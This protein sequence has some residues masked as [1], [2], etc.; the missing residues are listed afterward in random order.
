MALGVA[1]LWNEKLQ[2]AHG[3]APGAARLLTRD[4]CK[5]GAIGAPRIGLAMDS[6]V[7]NGTSPRD[8]HITN[9]LLFGFLQHCSNASFHR[10]LC[11]LCEEV[12]LLKLQ[13]QGQK[14]HDDELQT[15]GNR[16]SRVFEGE[17]QPDSERQ[18]EIVQSIARNLAEIGDSLDSSIQPAL[19]DNLAAQFQNPNLSEEDRRRCLAAALDQLARVLP[20]D[21]EQEKMLLTLA[22][23]LV[24]KVAAR[25]PS[26]LCSVFRTTASLINQNLLTYLRNL[27]RN[28]RTS[29]VKPCPLLLPPRA[30]FPGSTAGLW[31]HSLLWEPK[32][33]EAAS[34]L[35]L[36]LP[37]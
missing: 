16:S 6:Q 37:R 14:F 25:T 34:L 12:P 18:E 10:E 13:A 27:I 26:L 15:D 28:V 19:V 5:P 1:G 11:A 8:E 30:H 17:E 31:Q 7:S 3:V 33:Q 4:T 29:E 35:R 24:K 36:G 22:M 9:L 23:L 32:H 21:M 2:S 20:R